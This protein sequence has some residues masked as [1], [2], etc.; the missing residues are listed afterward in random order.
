MHPQELARRALRAAAAL[1]TEGATGSAA[2]VL[3]DLHAADGA[4]DPEEVARRLGSVV[5]PG[6]AFSRLGGARY[7]VLCERLERT[8]DAEDVALRIADAL[9]GAQRARVHVAGLDPRADPLAVLDGVP[10]GA[11]PPAP[12]VELDERRRREAARRERVRSALRSGT[13]DAGIELRYQPVASLRTGA[14]SGVEALVRW[15]LDGAVLGPDEFVP[16][17]EE[18]AAI[19]RIG[20]RVL[21]DAAARVAAWQRGPWDLPG[22]R[23]AVNVAP[24]Q[25]PDESFADAV[26]EVLGPGGLRPGT[27]LLEITESR[28]LRDLDLARDRL[29]LLASR[30]ARLAL[31]DFGS[32]WSS[33][34]YLSRLP[35]HA[36]KLD[37]SLLVGLGRSDE[38]A[39][40][41]RA[42]VGL[43]RELG[44]TCIAEGVERHEQVELLRELGCDLVQGTLVSPPLDADEVES[45]LRRGGTL[46]EPVDGR[47]AAR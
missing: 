13:E 15:R 20:H 42:V 6:D 34:A 45:L 21:R 28:L 44:R 27:L 5:R 30:G 39:A 4:P 25:L 12:W 37:R 46:L 33:L 36:V 24:R 8:R 9:G 7:V 32:G 43:L 19:V 11:D 47:P 16:L 2:L 10:E 17:A 23:L 35:V 18:S 26:E 41:V 31:D 38:D 40:I 14:I 1:S 22:L 3:V 29:T